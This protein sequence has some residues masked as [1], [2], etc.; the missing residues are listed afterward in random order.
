MMHYRRLGATGL[1]V[2]EIGFGGWGI[3]GDS[4]GLTEDSVSLDAVRAAVESGI[5]F[6]D[7]SDLYGRGRSEL[8]LGAALEGIRSRVKITSKVG[9]GGGV[10]RQDFS[11]SAI[12]SCLEASLRRLRTDYLDLYLLHSPRVED[13]EADPA[14]VETLEQ[15]RREGKILA[16]GVSARSPADAVVFARHF[17]FKAIQVNFNLLDQRARE[18]GLFE[19]AGELDVG[20]IVRTPL[21]FGFL[22][23]KYEDVRFPDGDHRA[24]WSVEQRLAWA[25][26]LRKFV[27][28]GMMEPGE[29]PI[30]FA[31]RFC[32]SQPGVSS[33]IPGILVRQHAVENSGASDGRLLSAEQIDLCFE[34][35]RSNAFFVRPSQSTS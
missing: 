20:L 32:L 31:L 10:D 21:C 30:R 1:E 29:D 4:Y 34:T 27:R 33:A 13:V 17:G 9:S 14:I 11:A 25:Q 12:R 7:T 19:L 22:T 6:F 3:G 23:G 5:N 2:S 24:L 18:A 8:L 15:L 26:G 16:C 28:R 35:Y